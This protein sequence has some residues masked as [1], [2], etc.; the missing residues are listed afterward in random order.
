MRGLVFKGNRQVALEDFP[1]PAPGPGEVLVA[2]RASGICG[3]DLNLYRRRA[4]FDRS[5]VC[6]HEPCGVVVHR[7][8]DVSD[9]DAPLGQR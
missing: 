9:R 4:N 3:S 5:V 8:L 6:G 1:E 2:M 7:G